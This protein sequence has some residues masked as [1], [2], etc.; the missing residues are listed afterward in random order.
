MKNIQKILLSVF[1]LG[2]SG[3]TLADVCTSQFGGF[4]GTATV[5]TGVDYVD[6]SGGI[7]TV[8]VTSSDQ[9]YKAESRC[10]DVM[11]QLVRLPF[12]GRLVAIEITGEAEAKGENTSGEFEILGHAS[13]PNYSDEFKKTFRWAGVPEFN[14]EGQS[15]GQQA[16]S[17]SVCGEAI[18]IRVDYIRQAFETEQ[19]DRGNARVDVRN[20]RLKFQAVSPGDRS[21]IN[22]AAVGLTDISSP[23][24]SGQRVELVSVHTKKCVDIAE[25]GM[26]NGA[27][28]QQWD[29]SQSSNQLFQVNVAGDGI[30]LKASHSN[31]CLSIGNGALGNGAPTTQTVDCN[32]SA[33]KIKLGP[34]ST[35]NAFTLRSAKSGKC[36]DIDSGKT[37]N[38]QKL[39]QWECVG[40]LWQEWRINVR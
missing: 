38:G 23:F 4:G 11:N 1:S 32:S 10:D 7:S 21:C 2:L 9:D 16:E 18:N 14:S 17:N 39:Q 5:E 35:P 25:F 28:A 29:C 8:L 12:Y 40:T 3:T 6:I 31:Q 20:V 13:I 22:K 30:T 26:W 19:F 24:S 27:S 34:A 15:L 37:K 36:L 33:A